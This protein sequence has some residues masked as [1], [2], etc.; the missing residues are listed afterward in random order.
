MEFDQKTNQNNV[1]KYRF[2]FFLSAGKILH[3]YCLA[4]R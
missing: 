3:A 4:N 2:S 1:E